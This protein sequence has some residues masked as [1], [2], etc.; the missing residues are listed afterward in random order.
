M[1]VLLQLLQLFKIPIMKAMAI[2]GIQN[3]GYVASHGTGTPLGDP[4]ETGALR[5]AVSS[6]SSETASF[7]VG[8]SKTLTGHLEGTAG[9]AGLTLCRIQLSYNFAH[10]LRYR[11]VLNSFVWLY[12]M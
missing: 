2:A 8:A 9:L 5:K 3:L 11:W 6:P 12:R 1:K 7:T 4:I 10:P